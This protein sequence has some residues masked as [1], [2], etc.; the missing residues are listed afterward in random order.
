MTPSAT[1]RSLRGCACS[2]RPSA[3]CRRAKASRCSA[4]LVAM[5]ATRTRPWQRARRGPR[6]DRSRDGA[7]RGPSS[8]RWATTLSGG[9]QQRVARARPR[10]GTAVLDEPTTSLIRYDDDVE[11]L[12]RLRDDGVTV[13]PAT[14][15]LNLAARYADIGGSH[16]GRLAAHGPPGDVLTAPTGRTCVQWPVTSLA[17]GAPQV[18]PQSGEVPS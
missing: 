10:A 8:D 11:L 5:D 18:T 17:G 3:W 14:H 4:R 6:G 12:R 13:V 15:N 16:A 2:R 9:E 1:V 7:V